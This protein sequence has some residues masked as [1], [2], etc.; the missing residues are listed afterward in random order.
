MRIRDMRVKIGKEYINM[1]R[2]ALLMKTETQQV[3]GVKY[4][5][6]GINVRTQCDKC[7]DETNLYLKLKDTNGKTV[8]LFSYFNFIKIF[9]QKF[10]L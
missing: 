10:D 9:N 5:E 8:T 7:R 1:F 3:V 4:N 2:R 6:Q